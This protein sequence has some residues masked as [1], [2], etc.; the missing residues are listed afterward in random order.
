AGRGRAR[1]GAGPGAGPGELRGRLRR[2][3]T[4]K[5]GVVR[6]GSGLAEALAELDGLAAALG[7]PGLAGDLGDPGPAALR[8]GHPVQLGRAVTELA[9]RREESRGGHW[10]SDH[11]APVEVW[12]VRQAL[13]RTAAGRLG[14]GL[15]AV[16]AGAG[17]GR[18]PTH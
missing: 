4:E 7:D 10:R 6:S 8:P 16:P 15:L 14:A 1:P 12:R 17:G 11:P 18:A 5:V 9:A 13:T 3:M 2:L